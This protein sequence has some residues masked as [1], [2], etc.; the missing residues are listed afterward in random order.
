MASTLDI[1]VLKIILPKEMASTRDISVLK[2]IV[3]KEMASTRDITEK[4]FDN[5]VKELPYLL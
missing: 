4:T 1:S 5:S 3:P 2:I